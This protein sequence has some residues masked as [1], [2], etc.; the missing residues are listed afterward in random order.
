VGWV[1]T[2]EGGGGIGSEEL[3]ELDAG[4]GGGT[5]SEEL[6]AEGVGVAEP[7]VAEPGA[8]EPGATFGGAA[9]PA[10]AAEGVGEGPFGLDCE[11]PPFVG[12]V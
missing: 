10:G 9:S 2:V 5:G 8:A 12:S 4:G 7:G 3:G 11:A 6:G 1:G